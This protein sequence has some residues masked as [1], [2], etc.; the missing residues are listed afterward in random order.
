MGG[1]LDRPVE[2]TV[3][4]YDLVLAVIPAVFVVAVLLGH[5]LPVSPRTAITGAALLGVLA[6]VDALFVNPPVSRG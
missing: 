1:V 3:S 5:L 2:L 6:M 4:R